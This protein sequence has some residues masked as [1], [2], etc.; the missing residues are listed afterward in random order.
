MTYTGIV[1]IDSNIRCY[2]ISLHCRI[3]ASVNLVIIGSGNGLSPVRRQAITLT[4]ACLLSIELLRTSLSEIPIGILSFPLMKML[5]KMLSAKTVA[6]F[7]R[8]G[9]GMSYY[10][11]LT[12]HWNY[13][14]KIALFRGTINRHQMVALG[15]AETP[16]IVPGPVDGVN[17]V[18][19]SSV[20][21]LQVILSVVK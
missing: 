3:Y 20:G 16:S 9:E 13:S 4:N 1:R 10:H 5:L 17:D 14:H 7:F 19:G 18:S 8:G 15:T 11:N 2:L 6:I 12:K 21:Q